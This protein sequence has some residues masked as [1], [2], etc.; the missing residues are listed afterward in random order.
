MKWWIMTLLFIVGF[1]PYEAD[2][3]VFH[4]Q[5]FRDAAEKGLE[6]TYNLEFEKA[7][8]VFSE[9]S[10]TWSEYPGPYFLLAINRWWQ[11]YISTTDAYHSYIEKNLQKALTLNGK[12]K[13]REGY[14]L[15]YTFFQYM[16]YA[17]LTRLYILRREWMKAANN[18]RKA[19]PFLPDGIS[20]TGESPE[21]FFSAGIYHYYAET[22]PRQHYYIRPFTI[23]FPEG[24]AELGLEELETA[25]GTPNFTR[26]ESLYYLGDIYLEEEKA[27]Q[28]ALRV[29]QK[30][31][32]MYPENTWFSAD[33]ARGLIYAGKAKDAEKLLQK[34]ITSF[35]ANKDF[36]TKH[37]SSVDSRL[38]SQIMMR[39]YHYMGRVHYSY[40]QNFQKAIDYFELSLKMANLAGVK[41]DQHLPGNYFWIGRS[42]DE[43]GENTKAKD[44]YE[45]AISLNENQ[46]VKSQAQACLKGECL[47]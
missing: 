43:L 44:A 20:L 2:A 42:Q 28:K 32:E 25:A 4:D 36:K 46:E 19:L 22:Y 33:Y 13:K 34:M 1:L 16:S 15:E 37:I 10:A 41:D 31:A 18:G 45:K 30:L 17:F 26:T 27:Y 38:T 9:M 29:K 5:A 39:V 12:L 40:H 6:F 7:D 21:F 47:D 14:D 23:F 8:Q 35:E 11:S 3:Q 24:N